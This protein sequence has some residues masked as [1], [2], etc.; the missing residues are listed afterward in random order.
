MTIS[1]IGGGVPGGIS[2][3]DVV[4]PTTAELAEIAA[5]YDLHPTSVRDCL[6]PDHLPKWE[7]FPTRLFLILRV[8][9]VESDRESA[10]VREITRK[11]AVYAGDDFVVTIH[12][13]QLPF[14][15]QLQAK[16]ADGAT[17]LAGNGKAGAPQRLVYQIVEDGLSTYLAPL[18]TEEEGIDRFEETLFDRREGQGDLFDL[19]LLRRRVMLMKRMLWRT[20][21]VIRSIGPG[22]GTS[23]A[24]QDL[25]EH[26][27]SLHFYADEISDNA[28]ALMNLYFA[29]ASQRTNHV[30]RVLTVFSA[31][32]LPLTFVVGVYG[33]NFDWMPELRWRWGYPA[34]WGVMVAITLTIL[35]WFRRR[36]WLTR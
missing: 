17:G 31:F 12:R 26:A 4:E 10:T 21:E 22:E 11:V 35:F 14:L 18:E 9:D 33:M 23:P 36:G 2:W 28:G 5:K 27:E 13:K 6:D 7:R 34:V 20:L 16:W 30:M 3:I 19:Y 25:R 15:Q 24:H 32:F 29:Q 8:Y 1:T